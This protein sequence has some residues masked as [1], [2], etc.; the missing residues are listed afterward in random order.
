M[1]SRASMCSARAMR[2]P[3]RRRLASPPLTSPR[4]TTRSATPSSKPPH[5]I[6]SRPTER[7]VEPAETPL[8]RDQQAAQGNLTISVACAPDAAAQ[9]AM[10]VSA[11]PDEPDGHRRRTA[12]T[13]CNATHAIPPAVAHGALWRNG[14]APSRSVPIPPSTPPGSRS[15]IIFSKRA[16]RGAMGSGAMSARPR[17]TRCQPSQG[18]ATKNHRHHP[19]ADARV[20][21]S[22][23][24]V[25]A[26]TA[27]FRRF[28]SLRVQNAAPGPCR[29]IDFRP[30]HDV[31]GC[32]AHHCSERR[33]SQSDMDRTRIDRR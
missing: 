11:V 22:C 24:V 2:E 1:R 16:H 25:A 3:T 28:H 8:H 30:T 19:S 15:L 33:E 14:F 20:R 12:I 7:S 21:F 10:D 17:R 29:R 32:A 18:R 13:S 4:C 31:R 9:T 23:F 27:R 26:I 6:G 5:A